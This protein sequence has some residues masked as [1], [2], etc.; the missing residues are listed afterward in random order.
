MSPRT[1]DVSTVHLTMC[2]RGLRAA[3][4]RHRCDRARRWLLD[5]ALPLAR[6]RMMYQVPV[7]ILS[8]TGR[9]HAT[10]DGA[11]SQLNALA[12]VAQAAPTDVTNVG[13]RSQVQPWALPRG[14]AGGS[15]WAHAEIRRC[16]RMAAVGTLGVDAPGACMVRRAAEYLPSPAKCVVT[17]KGLITGVLSCA[18]PEHAAR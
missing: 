2:L 5:A 11:L 1:S 18:Q 12:K 15:W 3:E 8:R 13:V 16:R 7:E 17:A 6:L 9:T 4:R 14:R 10:Q